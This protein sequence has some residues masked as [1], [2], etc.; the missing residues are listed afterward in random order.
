MS[1]ESGWTRERSQLY[2][3][4]T[5]RFVPFAKAKVFNMYSLSV[6]ATQLITFIYF[7]YYFFSNTKSV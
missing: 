6:K 2:Y 3:M 7:F 5:L 1:L 4:F